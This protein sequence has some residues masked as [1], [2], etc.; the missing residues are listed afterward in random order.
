[1]ANKFRKWGDHNRTQQEFDIT[2]NFFIKAGEKINIYDQI[3]AATEDTD[4]YQ[5]LEKYGSIKPLE[6]DKKAIYAEFNQMYDKRDLHNQQIAA[7]N[8]WDK[9]PYKVR[10]QFHN[11]KLEFMENGQKWLEN[12]ILRAEQAKTTQNEKNNEV[13]QN[14]QK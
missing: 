10:E 5:T 11:D 4:I 8:L 3:Q 1:M 12:E 6:I 7:Q 13:S 14:E 2:K 9:L